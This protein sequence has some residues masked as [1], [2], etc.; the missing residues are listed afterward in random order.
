LQWP[1]GT[2]PPALHLIPFG[3]II[4]V[5]SHTHYVHRRSGYGSRKKTRLGA[6]WILHRRLAH[7]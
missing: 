3:S 4:E 1:N 7:G 2:G 5:E 6:L